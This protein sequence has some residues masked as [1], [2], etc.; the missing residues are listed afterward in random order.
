[1]LRVPWVSVTDPHKQIR[2]SLT[3]YKMTL[4]LLLEAKTLYHSP[5]DETIFTG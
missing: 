5:K 3:G 1:M 4:M 2:M